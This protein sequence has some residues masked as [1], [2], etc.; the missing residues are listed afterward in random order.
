VHEVFG[1]L[2]VLVVTLL[3]VERRTASTPARRRRLVGVGLVGGLRQIPAAPAALRRFV[4][5]EREDISARILV[6]FGFPGGDGAN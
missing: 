3:R 4:V 6:P 2:L 5:Q 1:V